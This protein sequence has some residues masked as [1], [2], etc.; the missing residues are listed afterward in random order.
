M[1]S[2]EFLNFARPPPLKYSEMADFGFGSTFGLGALG[3]IAGGVSDA[4]FGGIKAKRQWKYQRKQM[5]LQQEYNKENMAIQQ[6]YNERNMG[7]QR[8]AELDAWN[9]E[10]EWN[11]PVAVRAR[12]EAAGISPQAALGG[13]ATGAGLATSMDTP[14]S[15]NPSSSS[16]SGGA[17][18]SGGSGHSQGIL[19]GAV[20]VKQL[21]SLDQQIEESKSRSRKNDAETAGINLDN[22]MKPLIAKGLDLDNQSK[23]YSNIIKSVQAKW[24]D[25]MASKDAAKRDVEIQN[26]YADLDNA[27]ADKGLKQEE[28]DNLIAMRGLIGA[29]TAT[30]GARKSNIEAQTAT[31]GARKENIEANTETENKLRDV[32]KALIDSDVRKNLASAGLSEAES[33]KVVE[34]LAQ[35]WSH[36]DSS[37]N[38]YDFLYKALYGALGANRYEEFR[39]RVSDKNRIDRVVE[40]IRRACGK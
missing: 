31:E 39:N 8:D 30:E 9:R 19:S 20:A 38:L 16:P 11:N 4:L 17:D 37:K 33:D 6:Q 27:I 23:E 34:E 3:D 1:R 25:I 24:A 26:L 35:L 36:T 22:A 2:A 28:R 10:N 18:Y 21:Q 32:R 13:G 5:A 12:Y 29:Q 7:L 40:S 14:S 15:S